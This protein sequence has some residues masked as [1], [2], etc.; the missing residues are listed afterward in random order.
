MQ[1]GFQR[2]FSLIIFMLSVQAFTAPRGE[3]ALGPTLTTELNA[4]LRNADGLHKSLLSHDEE[5]VDLNLR[6]ILWQLN[7]AKRALVHAKLH[8]RGHL[9]RILDAAEGDFEVSQTAVG[10]E[11]RL[12]LE[13]GFNQLVNLLQIYKLDRS[14]SIFFCPNDRTT[15]I[16]K[17]NS[18][19]NPFRAEGGRSPCAVRVPK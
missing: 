10:E 2:L 6:D 15:W 3:L 13:H 18:G 5:Q 14:Y 1:R 7:R 4:V 8:E 17:G 11:K 9:V 12:R 19:T 16:Q